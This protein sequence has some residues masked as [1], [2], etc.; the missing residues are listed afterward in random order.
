MLQRVRE[1]LR[2]ER[3]R[4]IRRVIDELIPVLRGWASDFALVDVKRPLEAL[5]QWMRRRLR[6]VIWRQWKRPATRHRKLRALGLDAYRA[7]KSA[8]NGRGAWWNAGASHMNQDLPRKWF[9]QLG[10]I[11]V[12]DTVRRLTRSL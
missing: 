6:Y 3:G 11:S 7:W 1:I 4:H 5:D 9:D 8:G 12:L 2:R 10:L